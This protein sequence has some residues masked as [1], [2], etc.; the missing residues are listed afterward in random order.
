[1]NLEYMKVSLFE[2]GYKKDTILYFI[3]IFQNIQIFEM[4][5]YNSHTCTCII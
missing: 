2:I 1:M 3:N 4:H 5:L